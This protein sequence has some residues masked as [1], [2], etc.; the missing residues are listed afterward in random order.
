MFPTS[1][2]TTRVAP[3]VIEAMRP[4]LDE[5]YFNPSSVYEPARLVAGA[6]EEARRTVAGCL[7]GVRPQEILFTGCATESNNTAIFGTLAAN[8]ARRHVVTSAV[9]HPAV[10]EVGRELERR[11]LEVETLECNSWLHRIDDEPVAADG[12]FP[13]RPAQPLEVIFVTGAL[14][15]CFGDVARPF[16]S[17]AAEL[18]A[19]GHRFQTIVVDGRSGTETNAAEIALHFEDLPADA[20]MPRVL[21]GYSKGT[22]DILRFL[23][24]YPI[25][26][27][28]VDAVVSVA[29]AVR[30]SPL[31]E[32]YEGVYDLV[33][34]HF[35]MGHCDAGDGELVH[36]LRSDVRTRWL[37]E[38]PLPDHLRYY[39]VAAFTTQDF[40]ARGL[41]HTWKS[42]LQHDR[43][44]DGQLLPQDTLI[45]GSTLLGY[46]NA[47][48][49][50]VA[51]DLESE[52]QFIAH[53]RNPAAFPRTVLIDA[54][55][56]Y[57]SADLR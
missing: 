49:W 50:A 12:S 43:R 27:E 51:L 53:R 16:R 42:L 35:P 37:K 20:G 9:E 30:G 3:E 7:G 31:A 52:H 4:Y 17:A 55:I 46:V 33:V 24:D 5:L 6:L 41:G 38:H 48:H 2:A 22:S 19:D 18:A 44:N 8:P 10:F 23:V 13:T 11:G 26:A 28:R 1:T 45:P 25:F 36:S 32:H 47:D 54:I 34:S 15:E 57:V 56:D 39:S 14:S 40:V 29:G 21:V